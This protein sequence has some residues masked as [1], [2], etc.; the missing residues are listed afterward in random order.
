MKFLAIDTSAKELVLAAVNGEKREEVALDCGMQHSVRLMEE[1]DG[2]LNRSALS[3]PTCD[4]L[5]CCVGPGSFTGIRIGISTVKGLCFA[6]GKAALAV[7]SLQ[8]IAYAEESPNKIAT[9]D[10]G[11]GFWYAEGYGDAALPAGYYPADKVRALALEK[12][13]A[14]LCREAIEG[15]KRVD[16]CKG[17]VAYA[18]AHGQ[19]ATSASELRAVYL[20]RSSAEEGR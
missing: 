1:V 10:A 16:V 20:R 19:E 7:T 14:L 5:V 18:I 13:A 6:E 2:I 3:L 15:A 4:F 8:A 12:G 17:I 9:V 11:H